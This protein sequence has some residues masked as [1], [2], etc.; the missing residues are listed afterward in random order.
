[1]YGT[2]YT[3]GDIIEIQVSST[4]LSS[5]QGADHVSRYKPVA[6]SPSLTEYRILDSINGAAQALDILMDEVHD[7]RLERE[8]AVNEGFQDEVGLAAFLDKWPSQLPRKR[9]VGNAPEVALLKLL[10]I[11]K[12]HNPV[13]L[14]AELENMHFQEGADIRAK[15]MVRPPLVDQGRESFRSEGS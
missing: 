6:G 4:F 12:M 5:W 2:N 8:T 13:D 7:K 15:L 9:N 10:K 3:A 14:Q 1:M 11:Y